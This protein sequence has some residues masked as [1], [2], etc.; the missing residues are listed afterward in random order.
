[1]FVDEI[2]SFISVSQ[3]EVKFWRLGE[4]SDQLLGEVKFHGS[5]DFNL[6]L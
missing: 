4:V 1:M 2:N 5:E 3:E 6:N